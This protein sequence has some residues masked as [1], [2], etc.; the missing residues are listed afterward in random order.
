MFAIEVELLA[1][2]FTATAHND[3]SCGEW[4]PHPARFFSA[5]VAALHE[6]APCDADE[7][8]A[9]LWLE[10][11]PPPSLDA[12]THVT[13]SVGRRAVMEVFV[14]VNDVSLVGDA[15]RP[16]REAQRNVL[17]LSRAAKTAHGRIS[18]RKAQQAVEREEKKLATFLADQRKIDP[19]PPKKA[20]ATA[21]ALLPRRRTRQ[22]RT[23]PVIVPERATFAFIWPASPPTQLRASLGKLC[24]RVTRLGHSSSAVRCAIVEPAP[25][26]TYVVDPDGEVILRTVGPGQLARLEDAFARHQGVESRT[27]PAIP[28]RYCRADA[29]P[30][31][32][33]SAHAESTF[34]SEWIVFRRTGGAR[35]LSSR[36]VD[37]ARA[38]RNS[39]LEQNG[40]PPLAESL[41]GHRRDGTATDQPHIA[42]V[43]LPF[44]G[45]EHAD[46]SI[47]G[48][49][50]VIPS[51]L[52]A[53]DR[54]TLMRLVAD[55][56][57]NR[58]M[59]GEGTMEL[60][61]EHL[62]PV[63][64]KRV[65][66]P[67]ARTLRPA[68]WCWPAMRYVTVTPIALDRHPGN[69]RS[70]RA[71]TAHRACVEAQ[72]CIANAC[73]RIGL[74]RPIS[75]EVSLAPMLPGVQPVHAFLPWPNR[76]GRTRRVRVHADIRF[77][78]PVKGPV[79]L[80]AGRF[81]GLGL[82]LPVT[83]ETQH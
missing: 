75:V 43:A 38:L 14:P 70:N 25:T 67:G 33:A 6:H 81:F 5:L 34:S 47:Q 15:E 74:P 59:D 73:E 53:A 66:L 61:G 41:S 80:G 77:A 82:C 39:L 48:C 13:E 55:W 30:S 60:A 17:A 3:R 57:N 83:E 29:Y 78:E 76:P 51:G 79:M 20:L 58:S 31:A 44:V 49:A 37:L 4:P 40:A 28:T 23:F 46:A 36:G 9:L 35:L 24:E 56:E 63:R 54:S 16:L 1:G 18:L 65:E 32:C 27:L 10:A 21:L 2:R 42:F 26:P 64:V 72:Q 71:A 68:R 52:S 50:I 8:A 19:D 12:D 22:A 62:P 7:R 69:L 11:Q 45:H